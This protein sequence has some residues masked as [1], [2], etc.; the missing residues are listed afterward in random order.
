MPQAFDFTELTKSWQQQQPLMEPDLAGVLQ[1][2]KKRRWLAAAELIA[3][4][5]MLACA[6]AAWLLLPTWLGALSALFLAGGALVQAVLSWKLHLPLL[7]YADWSST[8]LLEFRLRNQQASIRYL[9]YNQH[10]C[11]AL[12]FFIL[13]MWG[14][15]W[16]QPDQVSESLLDAYSLL[17]APFC[18]AVWLWLAQKKRS[19]QTQ[20]LHLQAL[21]AELTT[22]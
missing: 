11:V 3:C 14:L 2:Q 4:S 21:V 15:A 20:L 5:V 7:A 1:K 10:S 16:W 8:G 12:L 6:V 22:G 13:L 9:S 18:L 19:A 17:V